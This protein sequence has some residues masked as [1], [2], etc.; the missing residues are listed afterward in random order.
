MDDIVLTIN[1]TDETEEAGFLTIDN[2]ENPCGAFA[3]KA[4]P[5]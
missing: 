4:I 2:G 1:F 5:V 3:S